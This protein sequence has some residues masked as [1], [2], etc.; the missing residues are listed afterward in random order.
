MRLAGSCYKIW[1]SA[2]AKA[3][4]EVSGAITVWVLVET[5][6]GDDTIGKVYTARQ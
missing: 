6:A 4:D 5:M 3:G 2:E 1:K